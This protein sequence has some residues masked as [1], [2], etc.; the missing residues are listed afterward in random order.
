[1]TIESDIE[2]VMELKRNRIECIHRSPEQKQSQSTPKYCKTF[3]FG[4]FIGARKFHAKR[5][6]KLKSSFPTKPLTLLM[7]IKIATR[8]LLGLIY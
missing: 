8:A 2:S 3:N 7:M 1:M 5:R 4:N 6:K